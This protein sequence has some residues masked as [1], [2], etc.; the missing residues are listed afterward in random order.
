VHTTCCKSVLSFLTA[1]CSIDSASG[2]SASD[3]PHATPR[4]PHD[5]SSPPTSVTLPALK[6]NHMCV[7]AIRILKGSRYRW[8]A[9]MT[10]TGRFSHAD[11]L[12]PGRSARG[13][14]APSRI[15]RRDKLLIGGLTDPY[16]G[17]S[18]CCGPP[19]PGHF[20]G[21]ADHFDCNLVRKIL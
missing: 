8:T 6:G 15:S 16:F 14:A 5:S 17:D 4:A 7:R 21:L 20:G 11:R 2:M 10:S 3:K 13:A 9:Q 12:H 18:Q 1:R 19:L